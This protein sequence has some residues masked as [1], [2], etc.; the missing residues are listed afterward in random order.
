MVAFPMI[1]NY[2]LRIFNPSEYV[3]TVEI[4]VLAAV[5]PPGS[6]PV[7]GAVSPAVVV[8]IISILGGESLAVVVRQRISCNNMI[9]VVHE[10]VWQFRKR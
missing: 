7:H 9:K 8:I 4:R 5:V 2:S 1:P 3:A 10:E 6:M